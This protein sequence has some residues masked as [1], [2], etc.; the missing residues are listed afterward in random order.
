MSTKTSHASV[1][2]RPCRYCEPRVKMTEESLARIL[3]EYLAD[4]DD[5]VVSDEIYAERLA[6]C[7]SCADLL[8]GC[9]CRH[10]GC[11]VQ[12][13]ARLAAK[14]CPSPVGARW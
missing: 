8:G 4:H 2:E 10:C 12:V 7:M 6:E 11:F 9:T 5:A 13:R 14:H 1:S 3:A